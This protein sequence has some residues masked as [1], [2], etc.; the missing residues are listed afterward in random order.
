MY[1]QNQKQFLY[2]LLFLLS[3]NILIQIVF[4]LHYNFNK[5]LYK[6]IMAN[7]NRFKKKFCKYNFINFAYTKMYL[8]VQVLLTFKVLLY[9]KIF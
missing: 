6:K 9:R 1:I 3:T 5:Y 7:K 4:T 2:P 8:Q